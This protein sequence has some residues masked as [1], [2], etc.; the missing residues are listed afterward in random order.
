MAEP[1]QRRKLEAILSADVVGYSRLMQDDDAATVETLTKYRAIFSDFVN[2]PR[3]PHRGFAGRQYSRGSSTAR[4]KRCSAPSNFSVNS[5][6]V[7]CNSPITGRCIFASASTLAT[8][9]AV[10]MGPY[11]EMG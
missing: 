2:A 7:T 5:L 11:T 8:F 9:S 1:R 4:W 6:A 3:G 10:T